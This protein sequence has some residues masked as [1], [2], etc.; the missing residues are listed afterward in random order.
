VSD[1]FRA[2]INKAVPKSEGG[3]SGGGLLVVTD[4]GGTLDK[5][6]QEIHDAMLTGLV[7]IQD[8]SKDS[9]IN[10]V[11]QVYHDTKGGTYQVYGG[12][13]GNWSPQYTA[14]SADGYPTR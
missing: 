12:S 3:G 8:G 14:S 7:V 13:S 9:G 11:T 1:G 6:W 2:A 5:T 4:T 10:T